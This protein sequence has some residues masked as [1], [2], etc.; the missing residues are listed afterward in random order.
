MRKL[1]YFFLML[2]ILLSLTFQF[3]CKT[4]KGLGNINDSSNKP[5]KVYSTSKPSKQSTN[6]SSTIK[7]NT[8]I[9][10]KPAIETAQLLKYKPD[11][12]GSVMVV[13]FHNFVETYKGG[14]KYYT[15]T[16]SNYSKL[17]QTL[18]NK[19]YRLI[20]L[21]DYISNNIDLPIGLKP[22][23][24]TFDDGTASQ[25]RLNDVNGKLIASKQSAVGIMEEFYQSH[26]DFGLKGTFFVNLNNN[27]FAGKGNMEQRLKYLIDKGFEIGNHTYNH[28][29]LKEAKSALEIQ[30][31]IGKNQIE[32]NKYI[33][34]YIMQTFSMPYGLP[35]KALQEYVKRGEF[36]GVRYDNKAIMEVGWNPNTSP[37]CKAF[38][39]MSIH[40]V[41]ASGIVPVEADLAWWLNNM[42]N[43]SQYISDGD[44]NTF[45]VPK[46]RKILLD[47]NKI[48]KKDI[49]TY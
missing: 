37:I 14:D 31:E 44:P 23:V 45:T 28:I 25:F 16:Y 5:N 40:R 42:K 18:Y 15:T 20:N 36:Q 7:K 19:G 6:P 10:P 26:K 21:S 22:I 2:F 39:S 13:M 48:G 1:L 9:T 35:S 38:N 17:L 12:S 46:S 41:R 49:I 43:F 32:M 24:F 27:T 34:G 47:I 33:P 30:K 8:Y 11:E 29:N 4:N 3:A